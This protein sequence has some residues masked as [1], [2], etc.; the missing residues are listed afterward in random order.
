M[1]S[2]IK[3]HQSSA[4]A[5]LLHGG[6][7]SLLLV[8]GDSI[9]YYAAL[10]LTLVVR[11]GAESFHGDVF[12]VHRYA[13]TIGLVIWLT[14]FYIGGLY[15]R[16][17]VVRSLLDRRFFSLVAI[18][19]IVLIVMFYFST[20]LGITPKIT[21]F[22]FIGMYAVIGYAWRMTCNSVIRSAAGRG[23]I[24]LMIIGS[25]V[26]ADEV[27][28][29][30]ETNTSFGYTLAHWLKDGLQ[31]YA[32]P[33]SFLEKVRQHQID[34]IVIP[35]NLE[36]DPGAVRILYSALMS[37]TSIVTLPDFYERIFEKVSLSILDETWLIRNLADRRPRY[38]VIRR[39]AE[40]IVG[41]LV[42]AIAS[43]LLVFAAALIWL[44]SRGSI[45][46]RQTRVGYDG[47]KFTLYKFRSMYAHKEKNPDADQSSPTW[48]SGSHDP[49]ITPIGRFLRATHIDELPQFINIVRGEMSF[50]GPRPERPEF[51]VDLENQIPYYTLRYLV[52]PGIAGW[53]QLNYP[54]G[55]S[56]SDAYQKLQYDIYYIKRRSVWLDATIILK[57]IKRIFVPAE[58]PHSTEARRYG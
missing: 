54:Y 32:D 11:Y 58:H 33:S 41:A 26:A 22:I 31:A 45:L 6:A 38:R 30:I 49:R 14:V 16:Q 17:I 34:V 39:I 42:L 13:F 35:Q 23:S 19:G 27:V 28:T 4:A 56:T 21:L 5:F 25:S 57:T 40:P 20:S 52:R 18:G 9:S 7:R 36:H 29:A 55:A 24:R 15:D 48:S 43:P 8:I 37:G 44:T 12:F 46:Y 10:I 2:S 51:T 47:K 3:E 53:A 50:V 1:K